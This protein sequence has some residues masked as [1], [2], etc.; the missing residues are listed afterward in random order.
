MPNNN[1]DVVVYYG[2][3]SEYNSATKNDNAIYFITD[4][5][6]VY[7]GTT[8]YTHSD[9]IPLVTGKT[10][11]V[12]KFKSDGTIESTGFILEKSVPSDAKF[13]DTTYSAATLT[14][15]GLMTAA[16]KSKLNSIETEA[17]KTVVD[18]ALSST[19][20]NPV[21]NKIVDAAL[22]NKSDVGHTHTTVNGHTVESDVPANAKFTDTTY[23]T[24]TQSQSGL[25][26]AADKAK[27]EGITA[28]AT[29]VSVDSALDSTSENPVQNKIVKNALDG[30]LNTSLKGTANG[31]AELDAN[32]KVLSS[33]LP[34]YVDDCIEGYYNDDKFYSDSAHT[35]L[36]TGE[37]GKIYVNLH[38]EKIYRW[39]GSGYTVIS[40]TIALGETS[41]TA[42]RGDR[43]KIAY[44]HSQLTSGNPHNVTKTDIG[45]GNV[46]NKSSAIIRGELTSSDVTTALGFT[47]PSTDTTYSAGTGISLS[48]TTFNNSGVRSVS[49]G[50][51]NGTISVNTNGTSA[52]VAV[53]GLG[54][55]A[56]TPSTDYVKNTDIVSLTAA[57]YDALTEKTAKFYYIIEE[58]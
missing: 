37:S 46:E 40:E 3:Q 13:T 35:N 49:T 33:Q 32:G 34:S 58:E 5:N 4:S 55:A 22:S 7:V 26:S 2:T 29:A 11:E 50:E 51:T 36:I 30:K 18:D 15:N 20:T 14:E 53:K 19:S 10:G 28:G 12:A 45:L 8:E 57:E 44:D 23:D 21:Q 38:N 54:S 6:K 1:S 27:L 47:P 42:Y 52:D 17:N 56:Y 25:M 39:T 43:G 31:V 48:G 9:Y 41:S 24:A 16:D